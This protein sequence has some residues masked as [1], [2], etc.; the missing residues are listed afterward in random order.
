M[1]TRPTKRTKWAKLAIFLLKVKIL[2]FK[3]KKIE[4]FSSQIL[5]KILLHS[6]MKIRLNS[7]WIERNE[8]NNNGLA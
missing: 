8:A 6:L 5:H 2:N 1:K 4:I 7:N 3:E